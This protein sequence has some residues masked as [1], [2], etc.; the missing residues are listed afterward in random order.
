MQPFSNVFHFFFSPLSP[1]F[2]FVSWNRSVSDFF[3]IRVK[4]RVN[5]SLYS[6][7]LSQFALWETFSEDVAVIA[8]SPLCLHL[9][10]TLKGKRLPQCEL[11]Q[12]H[13]QF[14]CSSKGSLMNEKWELREFPGGP[15]VRTQC[16]HC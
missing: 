4:H 11:T 5:S 16:F 9:V 14:L 1:V 12:R 7:S 10:D 13:T 15:V 8:G 2:T 3:C 6:V